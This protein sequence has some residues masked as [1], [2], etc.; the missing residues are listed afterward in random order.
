M[1][2]KTMRWQNRIKT[3]KLLDQYRILHRLLKWRSQE[4]TMTMIKMEIWKVKWCDSL[5]FLWRK[6][7]MMKRGPKMVPKMMTA[8]LRTSKSSTTVRSTYPRRERIHTKWRQRKPRDRRNSQSLSSNRQHVTMRA[9][10]ATISNNSKILSNSS[11]K[12]NAPC[13]KR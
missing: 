7:L 4:L 3:V 13:K 6:K 5:R 9:W 10:N 12:E 8:H 1:L 2:K 11:S